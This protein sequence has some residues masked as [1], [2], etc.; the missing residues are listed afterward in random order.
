[1]TVRRSGAVSRLP[2]IERLDD[3]FGG[4]SEDLLDCLEDRALRNGVGAERIDV[5]R[6]GLRDSNC[7]GNLNLTATGELGSDDV[8]GYPAR[9]VAGGAVNLGW[10]LAA[11]CAAAVAAHTAISIDDDLA[12]GESGVALRASDDESPGG[13]DVELDVLV[14]ETL[15]DHRLDYLADDCFAEFLGGDI[16]G[17]LRR[18]DDGLDTNRN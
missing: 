2:E 13:I 15:G 9:G 7:V 1:M 10:V 3:G 8:L 14:A 4:Q 18:D 11:E 5:D 17:V 12:A 6:H 16:F